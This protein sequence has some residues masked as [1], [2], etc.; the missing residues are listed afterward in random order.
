VIFVE[1]GLELLNPNGKLGL[2]LPHKFFNAKYGEYLRILISGGNYLEKVV[3][4]GDQQ[5]FENAT[6]YTCLL[7]L[8]KEGQEL[9]EI[10]KVDDLKDWSEHTSNVSIGT[11]SS[12]R[13]HESEWNFVVGSSAEL[14]EKL[15]QM[16]LKLGVVADRIAQGIRT[17][18]NNIYV[19][20][21]VSD[22]GDF[23]VAYSKQLNKMFSLR[24][25]FIM[26]NSQF[27]LLIFRF[28]K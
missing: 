1:K 26:R 14:F 18:A 12:T 6:T 9:F 25:Q 21:L 3:H 7:F 23:V 24:T 17:S 13:A 22:K 5:V 27:I 28:I 2:I 10:L 19:V 8:D 4:F 16:P 11:F 15:A 20:D